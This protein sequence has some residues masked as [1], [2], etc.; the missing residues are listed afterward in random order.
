MACNPQPTLTLFSTPIIVT[1]S[2]VF[3]TAISVFPG[4]P[5]TSTAY[6]CEAVI[7]TRNKKNKRGHPVV[8]RAIPVCSP[9]STTRSSVTVIPGASHVNI[10]K[11]QWATETQP[12]YS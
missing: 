8:E 10:S 7:I 1:Q 5:I 4:D 9:G 6:S 2:L 12:R 11:I 3:S